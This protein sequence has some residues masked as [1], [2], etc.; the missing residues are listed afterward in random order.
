MSPETQTTSG[1]PLANGWK[2]DVVFPF[3]ADPVRRRL[4]FTLAAHPEQTATDLRAASQ[5]NLDLT[6]KRLASMRSDRFVVMRPDKVDKRRRFW[7]VA[8]G[9]LLNTTE[10]GKVFDFGFLK[11]PLHGA[12]DAEQVG[13]RTASA[14]W[15]PDAI[16]SLIGD[17]T[18]RKL[19]V[20]LARTPGQTGD[21]LKGK[22]HN[23]DAVLKHLAALRTAGLVTMSANA[24]D[25]RR[26]LYS[27][28]PTAPMEL[29]ENE[30]V[31]NFGFCTVIL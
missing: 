15:M 16:Y 14:H 24:V 1:T 3:F 9:V 7:S 22:A 6:M 10:T 4:L 8:P 25:G 20:T 27:I 30:V 17:P 31:F 13:V 5:R 19:L 21:Q 29:H 11:V 18:R 23:M 12:S 2:V 28:A 26:H